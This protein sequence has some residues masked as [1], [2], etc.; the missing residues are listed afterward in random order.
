MTTGQLLGVGAV[1]AVVAVAAVMYHRAVV[2][3][4]GKQA[5]VEVEK[6]AVG[7]GND[8]VRGATQTAQ[9]LF[10]TLGFKL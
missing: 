1:C 2:D 4:A 7:K 8:L 6:M 10:G 5:A 9:Q 3:A